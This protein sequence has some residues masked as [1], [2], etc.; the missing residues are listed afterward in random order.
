MQAA[1]AVVTRHGGEVLLVHRP[2]Y[3]DWSFP[4]GKVDP[5]EHVTAAAVREVAE[6]TGLD[7]RLG[8]PLDP[9]HYP[10]TGGRK[11]VHYW[12]G[13]VVGS[14][15]VSTYRP[16]AE[17]D[18][19]AWVHKKDAVDL[20]TYPYD[21]LTLRQ[22]QKVPHKTRAFVVL[23]HAKAWSRRGWR[24]DDR[25]RPLVKAGSLH[26]ERL[27][28]LLAAY[29]V[30]AV[31]TSSSKRCRDTVLPYADVAGIVPELLD[32][33]SEEDATEKSVITVVE[34]LLEQPA[35]VLLCTHRPVLPTVF[36][37]LGVKNP[38]LEPGALLVVHHRKGRVVATELFE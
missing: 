6:E 36:E 20:L 7:I 29:G 18:Q 33:L 4:K 35:G 11:T 26:S 8:V 30:E 16:N 24:A 37:A 22:G 15:D 9:Q 31:V 10:I 3:D 5:G 23:R 2:K 28:P 1:G 14:D 19:V 34:D 25:R 27:V 38:K 13:R 21:R 12:H 17:I 32:D